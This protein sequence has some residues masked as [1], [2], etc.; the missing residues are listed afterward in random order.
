[1]ASGVAS[2]TFSTSTSTGDSSMA[3]LFIADVPCSDVQL[4]SC[5]HSETC[6]AQILPSALCLD[7]SHSTW[8]FQNTLSCMVTSTPLAVPITTYQQ[9][10]CPLGMT[11]A[12][13]A[14]HSGGGGWCCPFG[15]TWASHSCQSSITGRMIP[16]ISDACAQE[17][18]LTSTPDN[19]QLF[20]RTT[21]T[22]AFYTETR[23][24]NKI[25]SSSADTSVIGH[26]AAVETA[27]TAIFVEAVYLSGQTF[28]TTELITPSAFTNGVVLPSESSNI[29][30]EAMLKHEL[31]NLA[32]VAIGLGS[33]VA[34]SFI[35]LLIVFLIW[36][37]RKRRLHET[38]KHEMNVPPN[39]GSYTSKAPKPVAT[40]NIRRTVLDRPRFQYELTAASSPT[41]PVFETSYLCRPDRDRLKGKELPLP[42]TPGERI[43][44]EVPSISG[45]T[46]YSANHFDFFELDT[47]PQPLESQ[48]S[49]RINRVSSQVLP[50]QAGIFDYLDPCDNTNKPEQANEFI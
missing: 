23:T 13:D 2:T 14:V 25:P 34:G 10:E 41:T 16:Q 42:L 28:P 11:T 44:S 15:F 38:E 3:T 50:W 49:R 24:F 32:K 26:R 21:D 6:V 8:T 30:N 46:F 45:T 36:R 43:K 12:K 9:N 39:S 35:I 22:P 37:H 31:P 29:A 18:V 48:A 47:Q 1:M 27:V 19:T 7:N 4:S 33:G 17:N 20:R 5:D 40:G